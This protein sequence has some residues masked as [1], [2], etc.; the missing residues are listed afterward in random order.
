MPAGQRPC[1]RV[2]GREDSRVYVCMYACMYVCRVI[3]VAAVLSSVV[4][5]PRD[6]WCF[7]RLFVAFSNDSTK[8]AS[9]LTYVHVYSKHVYV[10]SKIPPSTGARTTRGSC[11]L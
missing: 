9:R 8:D 1:V 5:F 2:H 6:Y 10:A 4:C 3:V 7:P 11:L